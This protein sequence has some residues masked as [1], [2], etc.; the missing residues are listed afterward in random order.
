VGQIIP[1]T[2]MHSINYIS[3]ALLKDIR[4][5]LD[6]PKAVPSQTILSP[7]NGTIVIQ[8]IEFA[9]D[10]FRLGSGSPFK[11]SPKV[12][13]LGVGHKAYTAGKLA[14]RATGE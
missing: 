12:T 1:V 11:R 8:R 7:N 6:W 2:K 10:P 5:Y 13:E 4:T 3:T 14:M 9:V